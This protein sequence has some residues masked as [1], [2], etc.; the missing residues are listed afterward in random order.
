MAWPSLPIPVSSLLAQRLVFDHDN[1]TAPIRIQL[2]PFH[3]FSFYFE[4]V[5][6]TNVYPSTPLRTASERA[7]LTLKSIAL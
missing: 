3:S 2:F 6:G 7:F 1:G 4:I 5:D